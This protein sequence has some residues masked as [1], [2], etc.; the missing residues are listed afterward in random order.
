MSRKALG[1]GLSALIGEES[2]SKSTDR[3]FFEIDIDLIEPNPDQPRKNF[4]G[5]ELNELAQ[6]IET[7][8]IVQPIVVRSFKGK[9]QIVAGERRW[10]AAQKAELKKVPAV[11]REVSDNKLLEIALIENIQRQ[12][13]N[14]VEES[15]AYQ[16]LIDDLGLTQEA[17]AKQVGK[18]RT[19]ITNYLRLLKLPKKVLNLVEQNKI[20]AGHARALISLE[21]K[22]AAITLAK[23]IVDSSMSVR[24]TEKAVKKV[25][26]GDSKPVTKESK[27][28]KKDPNVKNAEKKLRR[29]FGTQVKIL[30]DKDGLSGKIEFEYYGKSDLDRIYKLLMKK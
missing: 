25:L 10:R 24:D 15:R 20:S 29:Y 27:R 16:K 30:P 8:G 9:Y 2:E 14:P 18:S 6:S 3:T 5:S 17:V 7:N 28:L 12:E 26:R 21:S 11:V 13:L 23:Q 22:K 19:F 4:P 1:R